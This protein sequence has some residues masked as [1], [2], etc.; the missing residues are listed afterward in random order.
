[1]KSLKQV[2]SAAQRSPMREAPISRISVA[3]RTVYVGDF[4]PKPLTRDF[5]SSLDARRSGQL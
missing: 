4:I 3:S 1:M 2:W 5:F